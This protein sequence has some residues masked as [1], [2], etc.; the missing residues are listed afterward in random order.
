[1]RMGR[2]FISDLGLSLFWFFFLRFLSFSRCY[3]CPEISPFSKPVEPQASIS[4]MV[5]GYPS[6]Y[7]LYLVDQ[8]VCSG[9][10]ISS[11]GKNMKEHFSQTYICYLQFLLLAVYVSLLHLINFLRTYRYISI[12]TWFWEDIFTYNFIMAFMLL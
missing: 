8:K 2:V 11:Y 10:S 9:F 1:M 7:S 3:G 4:T 12:S 5:K 6:K